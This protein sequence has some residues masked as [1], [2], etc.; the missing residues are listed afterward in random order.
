MMCLFGF[1]VPFLEMLDNKIRIITFQVVEDNR[2][3]K[4]F[5]IIFF[6]LCLF[7]CDL[8]V[9]FG[10][11]RVFVTLRGFAFALLEFLH[12]NVAI[13]ARRSDVFPANVIMMSDLVIVFCKCF[14]TIVA[15]GG[16]VEFCLLLII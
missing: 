15:F 9:K 6:L 11:F 10:L 5:Y 14:I 2:Q 3:K 1:G 4:V 8:I 16:P 7:L 13:A 12:V